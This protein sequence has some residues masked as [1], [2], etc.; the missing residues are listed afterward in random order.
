[1]KFILLAIL[2][3]VLA[4]ATELLFPWWMIAA[5]P[6]ILAAAFNLTGG[7]SFIAGFLG[8]AVFW[9]IAVLMKDLPNDHILSR[10]MA[11]LF[12]LADYGLLIFVI[13]IVGG[14]VGGLSAWAGSLV[15]KV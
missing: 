15:R 7:T 4:A 1:M 14:V 13:S 11:T 8:I 10:R 12:H 2:T 9:F 3:G 6:F 5:V